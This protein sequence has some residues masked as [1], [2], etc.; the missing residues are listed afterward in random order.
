MRNV[1]QR[2]NAGLP[3]TIET[4][5]KPLDSTLFG[6]RIATIA[7]G[8]LGMMGAMLSVTGIFGMAAYSVS[9]RLKEFG[10]RVALGA[11]RKDV[12]WAALGRAFRLLSIGSVAGLVLGLLATR[13]LAFI[14]YQ[15]KPSQAKPSQARPGQAKPSQAKPSQ[16]IRSFLPEL[17][18]PWPSWVWRQHG[19]RRSVLCQ[20]IQ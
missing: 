10:I 16:A 11:Q 4:R 8:V 17:F 19:S 13:V 3:I 14:V 2:L 6:P 5:D 9:E 7:L 20:S 18:S 15:A 12:L 1:L